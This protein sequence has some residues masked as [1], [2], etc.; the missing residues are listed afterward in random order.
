M[1]IALTA[2]SGQ[3][4]ADQ[5]AD[6]TS[7]LGI[8]AE[9]RRGYDGA[10][11][12]W[13]AWCAAEGVDPETT[14]PLHTRAWLQALADRGLRTTT[15]RTRLA[16]L[17]GW[18]RLAGRRLPDPSHPSCQPLALWLRGRQRQ[19]GDAPR[20]VAAI[21]WGDADRICEQAAAEGTL[22]GRRDAAAI[23]VMSDAL[24]RIGEA[25]ALRVDDV[26]GRVLTIRSSKTTLEP[27]QLPLGPPT[28]DRIRAWISGA[29]AAGI[30][31][32]RGPLL[33]AVSTGGTFGAPWQP[34]Q[35]RRMIARRAEAIGIVGASGHSLRIG[36]AQSALLAGATTLELQQAG[37]WAS[38]R[39]P[40]AYTRLVDPDQAPLLARRHGVAG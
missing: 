38:D 19:T 6:A 20:Q 9:T 5:R 25:A 27:V 24:L 32:S 17:R 10:G 18:H 1:V 15:I 12:S 33:R 22:A 14:S 34:A 11:R 16:Q 2:R 31:M 26:A 35:L 4:A 21:R 23:A 28:V 37:R 40:A 36:S 13:S 7:R 3:S 39:M 29:S 8:S 30:D